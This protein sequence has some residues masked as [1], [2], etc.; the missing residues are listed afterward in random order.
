MSIILIPII[1]VALVLLNLYLWVIII[2]VVMG[3]LV[4]FGII[5]PYNRAIMIIDEALLRLTEPLL[6]PIRRIIPN[7][8]GLDLS[9]LILGLAII[10]IRSILFRI[11]LSFGA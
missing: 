11:G 2:S 8:G 5:N 1:E 9:P 10:L 7:L 4:A 3:W 6:Q